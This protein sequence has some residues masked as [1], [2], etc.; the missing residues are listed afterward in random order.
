MTAAGIEMAFLSRI[1]ELIWKG[2]DDVAEC[3]SIIKIA[4]VSEASDLKRPHDCL[5][6]LRQ[7][8][9][10]FYIRN[11]SSGLSIIFRRFLLG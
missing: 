8:V 9:A 11:A 2:D 1:C 6:A 5:H 4:A 3:I 10:V 7:P